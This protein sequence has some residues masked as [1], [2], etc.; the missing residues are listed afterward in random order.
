MP[1]ASKLYR[2]LHSMSY[3]SYSYT[4]LKKPYFQTAKT[5]KIFD[6]ICIF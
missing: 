3:S 6:K 5:G 2:R 4:L 1:K